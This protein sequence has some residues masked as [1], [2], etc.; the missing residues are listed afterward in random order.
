MGARFYR[1]ARR[2]D[3]T[4][5]AQITFKAGISSRE[6]QFNATRISRAGR[7]CSVRQH[8]WPSRGTLTA[9]GLLQ[10][11]GIRRGSRAKRVRGS[12]ERSPERDKRWSAANVVIAGA[13]DAARAR[14]DFV[15]RTG[16][17][18][19]GTNIRDQSRGRHPMVAGVFTQCGLQVVHDYRLRKNWV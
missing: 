9:V 16:D 8:K 10:N 18:R 2:R 1:R 11:W 3:T 14:A 19:G 7:A 12:R 15:E 17:K 6:R 4:T 5:N 13:H